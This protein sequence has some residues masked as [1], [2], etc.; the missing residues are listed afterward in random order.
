MT[1]R[2][3]PL[4]ALTLGLAGTA[5][6][7]RADEKT[8][9][10]RGGPTRPAG[11]TRAFG[12]RRRRRRSATRPCGA[13]C[14]TSTGRTCGRTAGWRRR[15]RPP[16]RR[17]TR[18]RR[19]RRHVERMRKVEAY[20]KV[21][22]ELQSATGGGSGG[23]GILPAGGGVGAGAGQGEVRRGG[24]AASGSPDADFRRGNQAG[25]GEN[26][27]ISEF[28]NRHG[29]PRPSKKRPESGLRRKTRRPPARRI[30]LTRRRPMPRPRAASPPARP[31]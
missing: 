2:I 24:D 1:T 7:V 17:R 21:Q 3:L 25:I 18:S 27:L 19:C 20:V 10:A 12:P 14:R 16:T 30:P 28:C 5:A 9:N 26:G 31:A 13:A 6:A 8:D 11:S 4:F 29:H 23:P 15:R 22:R